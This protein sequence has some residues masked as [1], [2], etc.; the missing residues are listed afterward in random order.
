MPRTPETPSSPPFPVDRL[1]LSHLRRE[2]RTA[3]EL[4]I[5]ALAPVELTDRLA[6]AAGMLEALTEVPEVGAPAQALLGATVDRARG[7]LQAWH[8]WERS[9]L[10]RG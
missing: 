5:V 4:A 2:A 9:H 1:D 6:V 8:D 7:A 10:S 3:L